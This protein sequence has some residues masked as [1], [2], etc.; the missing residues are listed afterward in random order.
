MARGTEF[1]SEIVQALQ[2]SGVV[3]RSVRPSTLQ[4]FFTPEDQAAFIETDNGTLEALRL[5]ADGGADELNI[6]RLD[7]GRDGR[8]VYALSKWNL[9][10]RTIDADHPLS[11][12]TWKKWLIVTDQPDLEAI[13]KRDLKSPILSPSETPAQRTFGLDGRQAA[14]V[15]VIMRFIQVYNEGRLDEAL[16]LLD[17]DIG[18]S[19]CDYKSGTTAK[20]RG[21]AQV[22]E[23]LRQRIADHDQLTVSEVFNGNPDPT[24]GANLVG[25][26][27]GRRASDSL[28]QLGFPDGID[29]EL[30]AKVVFTPSEPILIAWFAAGSTEGCDLAKS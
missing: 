8:Y 24:T 12:V 9:P 14:E 4:G 21:K 17:D 15:T 7:M 30:T 18:W 6:T 10:V 19:D 2:T 26:V 28:K 11:F 13:L 3:V 27:F 16:S 23:W 1:A 29:P 22:A 5:A 20:F 25:V